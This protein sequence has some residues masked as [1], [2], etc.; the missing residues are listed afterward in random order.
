MLTPTYKIEHNG[1]TLIVSSDN[2]KLLNTTHQRWRH[3]MD[4]CKAF[5]TDHI[6]VNHNL[7]SERFLL[8]S[9]GDIQQVEIDGKHIYKFETEILEL[10]NNKCI[11][12][13]LMEYKGVNNGNTNY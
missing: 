11:L 1:N 2:E 4:Y 7:N 6:M 8:I 12:E 3:M 13:T 10:P 5:I 9:L